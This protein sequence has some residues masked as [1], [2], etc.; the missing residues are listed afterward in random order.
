MAAASQGQAGMGCERKRGALSAGTTMTE[1]P[2]L[3][4]RPQQQTP[5]CILI[6]EDSLHKAIVTV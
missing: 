6:G 4:L 2:V 1:L 3:Y 5:V